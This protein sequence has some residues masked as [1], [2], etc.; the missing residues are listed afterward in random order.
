MEIIVAPNAG[1]CYGVKRA[2]NLARKVRRDRPG[3]VTT[4]GDLIHNP[5]VIRELER[6]G[7][8]SAD[9][10][11]KIANGTVI[12]RSHGVSPE[13]YDILGRRNLAVVDA[14]CP[15]V[16]GIQ[17][18]VA[19]LARQ[20]I[21]IIIVGDREHP[22]IKGLV[23]HSR[24]RAVVVDNEEDAGALPYAKKRAVLTQ[25]T[26]D[27]YLFGK[28]VARLL[29]R[30]DELRAYNTICHFTQARQTSTS[31]LAR[32][33]EALFIVGGRS[34]SNTAKL[35]HISRRILPRTHFIESATEIR[36][37]MLEGI[38]RV[39]ISGG[40]STPPEAIDEAV[41]AVRAGLSPKSQLEK[42]A[43]CPK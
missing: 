19:R 8:A 32:N 10:P 4:L 6:Q 3:S 9:D 26:Q 20:N 12:I 15:I 37:E 5:G 33:V 25:S 2:L 27:S 34:S 29:E 14:T 1:L 7:I 23:G 40:A 16:R 35:Y 28:I 22:E 18:R 11:E 39:G 30:T 36:P 24:G 13:V 31:E 41:R 17:K 42:N 38:R 21:D 43:P